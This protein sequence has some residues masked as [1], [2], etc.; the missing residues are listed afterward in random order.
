MTFPIKKRNN[1]ELLAL[2]GNRGF[3]YKREI[4]K[5]FKKIF[6]LLEEGKSET[7]EKIKRTMFGMTYITWKERQTNGSVFE[8]VKQKIL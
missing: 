4:K 5:W 1:T 2:E 7:A 8:L 3:I 6:D